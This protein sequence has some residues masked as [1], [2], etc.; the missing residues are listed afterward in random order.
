MFAFQVFE[1]WKFVFSKTAS[2]VSPKIVSRQRFALGEF[3]LDSVRCFPET[4]GEFAALAVDA[5][6]PSAT[7]L[8][9]RVESRLTRH[10]QS[11]QPRGPLAMRVSVGYWGPSDTRSFP[12]FLECGGVRTAAA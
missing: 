10:N 4:R 1:V 5:A 7:V 2:P 8:R 6:E 3:P 11:R 12:E 9:Q